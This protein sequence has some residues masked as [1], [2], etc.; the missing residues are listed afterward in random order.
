MVKT[1]WFFALWAVFAFWAWAYHVAS[2]FLNG[3]IAAE[4]GKRSGIIS[5]LNDVTEALL[6]APLGRPLS[7][8][9]LILAGIGS[10]A[11]V[12]RLSSRRQG[13]IS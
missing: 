11:L 3:L 2:G 6:V 9:L 10:A 7:V 1:P 13:D 4:S 8:V 5:V 12:Y